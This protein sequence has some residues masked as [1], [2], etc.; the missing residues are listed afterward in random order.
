MFLEPP[1]EGGGFDIW[2][3]PLLKEGAAVRPGPAE[4]F[5]QGGP[6]GLGRAPA[7]SPDGRW[8]AYGRRGPPDAEV[9]VQLF[10]TSSST[11]G[12]R[13]QISNNGGNSP[14][15]SRT[16]HERFYQSAGNIMVVPYTVKGDAF[17]A[18]RPRIWARLPAGIAAEGFDLAPDGKRFVVAA[19]LEEA[20]AQIEQSHVTFLLN[21]FD[22]LRRRAP[23]K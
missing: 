20:Q 16:A 23:A 4:P 14:V 15:W 7:V 11:P 2:T 22:E 9:Y 21:F 13:W 8:L 3:L 1:P 5:L 6:V 17:E 19:P 12:S 18:D 10:A